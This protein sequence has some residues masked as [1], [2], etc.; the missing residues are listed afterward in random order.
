MQT[1][2]PPSSPNSIPPSIPQPF[3][4]Q[5]AS[6][7][8]QA[9]PQKS[10]VLPIL[11]GCGCGFPILSLILLAVIGSIWGGKTGNV[12]NTSTNTATPAST[13]GAPEN[14]SL[15][16]YLGKWQG[17]DG[18]SIWIRADG[19]GDYDGGNTKVSG[20]GVTVDENAKTLAITS[21]LGIGKT[22]KIDAPPQTKN[23]QAEM[24]LNGA[25]YRRIEGFTV[26]PDAE[27][28]P[29]APSKDFDATKVPSGEEQRRL[30]E[31]TIDKFDDALDERDFT[32][33]HKYCS[34]LWQKQ[35][36]PRDL[37]AA[38]HGFLDKKVRV[39]EA[40]NHDPVFSPAP[41]IDENGRLVLQGFYPTEPYKIY[42]Q[43]SYVAENNAWKLSAIHIK[44]GDPIQ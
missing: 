20:G 15:E 14:A 35:V 7:A 4:S 1:P 2:E 40:L 26:V 38:F 24:K 16:K 29:A 9:P 21:F 12:S 41:K 8:S 33:F 11:L 6:Y 13:P 23:G 5:P 19:K 30:A 37:K 27:S 39:A 43:F 31:E 18:T 22:F 28:T 34:R 17:S 42:F 25:V 44:T 3:E 32:K 10:K 36:T